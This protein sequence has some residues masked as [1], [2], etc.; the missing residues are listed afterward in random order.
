MKFKKRNIYLR[1]KKVWGMK[2]TH[3]LIFLTALIFAVIFFLDMCMEENRIEEGQLLEEQLQNQEKYMEDIANDESFVLPS[4]AD[5]SPDEVEVKEEQEEPVSLDSGSYDA[6]ITAY[7][8]YDSCHTG[9]SCLMASG[10]KAYVGAAACP[11]SYSL[12]TMVEV[13]G[14]GRYKCEDRTATW[15]DGR[16][17]IFTGYGQ[18]GY[19]EAI[20]FGKQVRKI[21]LI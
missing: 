12:G 10:V 21:K 3:L 4:E 6:V 1:P 2:T 8:E 20:Q 13:E 5:L 14:L 16:I 7:S 17:D 11:R 19:N 15:V 9:A 18:E